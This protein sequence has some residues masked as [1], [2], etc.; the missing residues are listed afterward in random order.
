MRMDFETAQR[1]YTEWSAAEQGKACP[2]GR[3]YDF[4][5]LLDGIFNVKAMS[6]VIMEKKRPLGKSVKGD[7]FRFI[8]ICSRHIEERTKH[9]KYEDHFLDCW[10]PFRKI[11]E[12]IYS[13]GESWSDELILSSVRIL[14]AAAIIFNLPDN[15]NLD[16]IIS[17]RA[18]RII[19][20]SYWAEIEDLEFYKTLPCD[21]DGRFQTESEILI[22]LKTNL[23]FFLP[24]IG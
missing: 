20:G 14:Y 21:L 4:Y 13:Q 1:K 3:D 18:S 12:T 15:C 16:G 19:P 17:N 8:V 10:V 9:R 5:R 23:Q 6:V 22:G 11:I 7:L 2:W 24:K